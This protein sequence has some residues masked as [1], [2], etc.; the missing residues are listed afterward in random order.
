MKKIIN[1]LLFFLLFTNCKHQISRIKYKVDIKNS[2]YV[3]CCLPIRKFEVIPD[4]VAT[5]I[6]AIRISDSGFSISCSEA[7][8]LAILQKEGCALGAD[9]ILITKE[10]QPDDDSNCYRCR[11]EFYKYNCK[12]KS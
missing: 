10:R 11:A 8:A 9:F 4:S 5:R 6:G 3:D 1:L 2:S 7:D 12:P